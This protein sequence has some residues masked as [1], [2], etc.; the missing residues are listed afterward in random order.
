MTTTARYTLGDV[1]VPVRQRVTEAVLPEG[2]YLARSLLKYTDRNGQPSRLPGFSFG[3][4][5]EQCRQV[6][7]YE[8]IERLAA[9]Y[10]FQSTIADRDT[11]VPGHEWQ[12]GQSTTV[13]FERVLIQNNAPPALDIDNDATGLAYHH[14]RENAIIHAICELLERALFARIWWQD[15]S[16]CEVG[17]AEN[18]GCD[19]TFRKYCIDAV[20]VPPFV[21]GTISNTTERVW[22]CAS[23][24]NRNPQAAVEHAK[25][26]CCILLDNHF[27][28]KEDL[29][30]QSDPAKERRLRSIQSE[31]SSARR[32]H[33]REKRTG[34][35]DTFEP[36]G[37]LEDVFDTFDIER[38][39]DIA[40]LWEDNEHCVVRATCDDIE[41]VHEVRQ[42]SQGDVPPDIFL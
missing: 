27:S 38:N 42:S 33:I 3:T 40:T 39:I 26:E 20:P 41:G 28:D 7:G 34:T 12:S 9:T 14:N 35:V 18:V 31:Q 1:E 6:S 30:F 5:E 32:G 10:D 17:E 15:E 13:P 23:A 19:Y 22:L 8:A 24:L 11:S 25:E 2:Y 4:E 16:L 36:T 21:L 37:P 29:V